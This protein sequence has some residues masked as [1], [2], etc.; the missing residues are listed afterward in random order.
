MFVFRYKPHKNPHQFRENL[1]AC[2]ISS[3]VFLIVLTADITRIT[4]NVKKH[5]SPK[6]IHGLR[7]LLRGESI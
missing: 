2:Q 5:I 3:L 7:L 1:Q 4:Y 6:D